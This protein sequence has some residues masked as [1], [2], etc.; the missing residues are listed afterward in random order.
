M[1][2][3]SIVVR[4][5]PEKEFNFIASTKKKFYISESRYRRLEALPKSLSAPPKCRLRDTPL[6][7]EKERSYGFT[8]SQSNSAGITYFRF[9]WTLAIGFRPISLER[10][11]VVAAKLIRKLVINVLE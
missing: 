6:R 9:G 8:V 3:C 1:N 7:K 4:K 10:E 5:S 2:E 11:E